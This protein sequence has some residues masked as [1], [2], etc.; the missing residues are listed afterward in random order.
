MENSTDHPKKYKSLGMVL[1]VLVFILAA[2]PLL[3]SAILLA[4]QDMLVI[5]PW[6]IFVIVG[7]TVVFA[8]LVYF[9]IRSRVLGPL[10]YLLKA[11]EQASRGDLLRTVEPSSQ[12]REIRQI[13]VGMGQL[14]GS[15][16]Q[17]VGKIQISAEQTQEYA[18][19]LASG[20][21]EANEAINQ[22]ATTV[23]DISSGAEE[24]SQATDQT[25]QGVNER[26]EQVE[27][28]SSN[29]KS[30]Q[31]TAEQ[32]EQV[33][34]D[35]SSKVENLIKSSEETAENNQK[36]REMIKKLT[37]QAEKITEIVNVVTDIS[38]QTHLLALNASIEAARAG[39]SGQGFAVVAQ[40]VRNLAEES[41]KSAEEISNLIYK[42]KEMVNEADRLVEQS[43]N[44]SRQ[45]AEYA[46]TA[47]NALKEIVTAVHRVAEK[48]DDVQS[49]AQVLKES[50]QE[51]QDSVQKINEIAQSNAA[52]AEETAASTQ[53]HTA[54]MDEM[55][56]SSDNLSKISEE[57]LQ[58]V[59]ETL[60]S[61]EV[62]QKYQDGI[63][64]IKEKLQEASENLKEIEIDKQEQDPYLNELANNPNVEM[65]FTTDRDGKIVYISR[66]VG[67][68]DVSY[69]PWYKEAI[70]GEEY[71]SNVYIS[72]ANDRPCV[73]V[74]LPILDAYGSVK[75]VL[76]ADLFLG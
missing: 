69:R 55:N 34:E 48:V 41:G 20:I 51:V 30:A 33:I 13:E 23:N 10:S 72:Q 24:Q 59:N 61:E 42:V 57:L 71:I 47:R 44:N 58:L 28:I 50:I 2:V 37:D 45:G 4:V 52:G 75:G 31:E 21:E 25:L 63:N 11:C 76:G 65:L 3:T 15:L 66:D 36:A 49:G 32:M 16:R 35:S 56:T 18:K 39:D 53:E 12:I 17:M 5:R 67:V 54:T 9:Y 22:I 29:A 14:F 19:S 8:L 46:D 43:V 1:G 6:Q 74:S 27:R 73:T 7:I 70:K 40:E 26:L 38:E 62:Y 68:S 64:D 60:A